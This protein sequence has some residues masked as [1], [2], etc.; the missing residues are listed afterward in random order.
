MYSMSC[1]PFTCCSMAAATDC[2]TTSALAPGSTVLTV[3]CGGTTWGYWAIGRPNAASAPVRIMMSA[4]TVDRTGRSMKKFSM[5]RSLAG[6]DLDRLDRRARA[7]LADAFDHDFF[8]RAQ[9]ALHDP[10]VAMAQ[11]RDDR[12]RLDLVVGADHKHRL[13][14]LQLPHG[15]L[16]NGNRLGR[17]ED[18]HADTHEE[19]RPQD[20]LGVGHR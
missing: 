10:L 6:C 9:A 13:L 15:L 19:A 3:T 5:A 1:E 20:P 2:D 11:A 8:A 7:D 17:F 16:R 18:R 12:P 4:T 14:S